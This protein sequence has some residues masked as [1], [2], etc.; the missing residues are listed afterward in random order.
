M[1]SRSVNKTH[2]KE[3][4]FSCVNSKLALMIDN[5][6]TNDLQRPPLLLTPLIKMSK[7]GYKKLSL[8]IV[9]I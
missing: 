7:W 8:I 9:K 2:L 6:F 1:P 3:S 5:V 4:D